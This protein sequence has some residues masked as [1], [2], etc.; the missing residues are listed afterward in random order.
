MSSK[1][2]I[3]FILNYLTLLT[4]LTPL[5]MFCEKVQNIIVDLL[6]NSF[7]CA[8]QS[9]KLSTRLNINKNIIT[10]NN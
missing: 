5:K 9:L 7:F 1:L 6:I 8:L 3:I 10:N 2:E 4:I